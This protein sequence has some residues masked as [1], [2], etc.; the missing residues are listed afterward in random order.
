MT[1]MSSGWPGT[2]RVAAGKFRAFYRN[3]RTLSSTEPLDVKLW[4]FKSLAR[5]R[6][7][8]FAAVFG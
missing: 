3:P 4:F 1:A 7:F 6:V 5:K 2:A 8:A